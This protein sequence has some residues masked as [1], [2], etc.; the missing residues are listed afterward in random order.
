MTATK[1]RKSVTT[2]LA[3]LEADRTKA[4]AET[5][6]A[7]ARSE[8]WDQETEAKRAELSQLIS[9]RDGATGRV[10]VG[11]PQPGSAAAKL[12]AEIRDR[13]RTGNPHQAEHAQA[14]GEFHQADRAVR[15][16]KL[17]HVHDRLAELDPEVDAA[18]EGI[19][20]A[21][22]ALAEACQDYRATVETTRVVIVDTPGLDREKP[23]ETHQTF[24]PNVASWGEVAAGIRDAEIIRPGLT[25]IA[26]W[27]VSRDG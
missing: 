5:K 9:T 4:H 15:E 6:E 25:P 12:D 18:I 17:E 10:V 1:P 20:S 24:D 22:A 3:K 14:R 8:A 13:L 7:K 27:K 19:R 11:A 21:A 16:F 23:N 2:E 26:A